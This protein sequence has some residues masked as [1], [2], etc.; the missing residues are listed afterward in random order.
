VR[1]AGEPIRERAGRTRDGRIDEL[2]VELAARLVPEAHLGE[3]AC[4]SEGSAASRREARVRVGATHLGR[5]SRPARTRYVSV[6][7]LL[8]RGERG[9]RAHQD[10]GA[11]DELSQNLLALLLLEVEPDT[12]LAPVHLLQLVVSSL[13]ERQDQEKEGRTW[14]K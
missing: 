3:F 4:A 6:L 1:A 5:S 14:R 8:V 12:P 11:L 2:R 10:V 13:R 7:S 9:T